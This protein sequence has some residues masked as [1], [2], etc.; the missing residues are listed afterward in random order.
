M[1]LSIRGC[2]CSLISFDHC[3]KTVVRNHACLVLVSVSL[4]NFVLM[5]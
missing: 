4:R 1:Y 5:L 2:I 3:I